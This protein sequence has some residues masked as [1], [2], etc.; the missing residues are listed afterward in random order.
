VGADPALKGSAEQLMK[1][2]AA[3][4]KK[5][6]EKYNGKLIHTDGIV[7]D[8]VVNGETVKDI[9][10]VG[11]AERTAKPGRLRIRG[12]GDIRRQQMAKLR[13]LRPGQLVHIRGQASIS[14]DPPEIWLDEPFLL[15]K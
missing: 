14:S 10:L 1:D 5:V 3:D 11:T 13:G 8:V 9:F 2:F 4:P 7:A 12:T 6:Q 15:K